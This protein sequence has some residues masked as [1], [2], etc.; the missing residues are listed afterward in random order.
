MEEK[1]NRLYSDFHAQRLGAHCYPNEFLVRTMLG[2]YSELKISHEYQGK[3]V[4]DWACGDGRN[5]LLLHNC[6]L[7]VSAFEITEEICTGVEE[8]MQ[9][10]YNIPIDIR[11]GR[12]NKVPFADNS[13]DYIV[14]SSSIYYVDH[15]SNFNE[16]YDE[17]CRVLKTGG[18]VIMTL[19]RSDNF[20]LKDCVKWQDKEGHYQIT[21][22]PYGL[23]NGDIFRVWQNEEEIRETF[24]KD[25]GDICIGKT[26]E[27]YYGMHIALWLVVMRKI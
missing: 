21:N 4:L 13:F 9:Q 3:K 18:Y 22:D 5:I 2:K 6:G 14:A 27:D 12:N 15:N 25:F 16:N 8:R 23:R 19:S 17:L 11:V 20:I 1:I 24:S 10:L 7:S 26:V